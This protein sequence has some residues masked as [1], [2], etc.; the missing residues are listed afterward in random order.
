MT[1]FLSILRFRCEI[2]HLNL[3]FGV[4]YELYVKYRIAIEALEFSMNLVAFVIL[5]MQGDAFLSLVKFELD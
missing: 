1:F 2:L 5:C 4:Q 3:S